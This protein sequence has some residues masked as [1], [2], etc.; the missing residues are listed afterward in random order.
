M[1][2]EVIRYRLRYFGEDE[3]VF[4]KLPPEHILF[5]IIRVG[6]QDKRWCKAGEPSYIGG[7]VSTNFG[8]SQP[9]FEDS[10]DFP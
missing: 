6:W 9:V 5:V 7:Q 1:C 3:L 4:Q 10:D 2:L 8:L